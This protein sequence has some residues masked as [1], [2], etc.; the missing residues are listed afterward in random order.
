MGIIATIAM[1][2]AAC[3]AAL[4]FRSNFYEVFLATHIA[5]VVLTLVTCWYHLVPHFGY[6]FGY[7]TWL[8][9]CFAFWFF[10]RFSRIVRMTYYN[11]IGESMG[12]VEA[13]PGCDVLQV[14]VFP[15]VWNFGPG[16]HSFL[17]LPDSSLYLPGLGAKFWENHPFSVAGW[18]R[19][20][21][22]SLVET[23]SA[24]PSASLPD[25][26]TKGQ[27]SGDAIVE[28]VATDSDQSSEMGNEKQRTLPHQTRTQEYTSIQFLV[29]VHRGMTATLQKRVLGS[30][31]RCVQLAMYTEGP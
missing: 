16:Q 18:T 3:F 26:V 5:L 31:S 24:S 21:Q 29:R 6:V 13:V 4:P 17:Y 2:L 14:T 27:A 28:S 22:I 25:N 10:D 12:I 20:G 9:V 11:R 1:C 15:R 8:Y 23:S 7:Q 30:P 19:S